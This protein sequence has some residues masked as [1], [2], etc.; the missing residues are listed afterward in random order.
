MPLDT[1]SV[2]SR[3]DSKGYI[4][5]LDKE[6]F[7]VSEWVLVWVRTFSVESTHIV[8]AGVA[9]G[10]IFFVVGLKLTVIVMV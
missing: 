10:G 3:F 5:Y 2:V 6:T 1:V 7:I 4:V 8:H 9:F